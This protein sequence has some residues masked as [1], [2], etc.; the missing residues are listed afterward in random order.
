M[1]AKTYQITIPETAG[2]LSKSLPQSPEIALA[3][4][5]ELKQQADQLEKPLLVSMTVG[6]I[7][8]D[9]DEMLATHD[10]L[11]GLFKYVKEKDLDYIFKFPTSP[12]MVKINVICNVSKIDI[13]VTS[14]CKQ[15]F[16]V[17]SSTLNIDEIQFVFRVKDLSGNYKEKAVLTLD[18]DK[19]KKHFNIDLTQYVRQIPHLVNSSLT[20]IHK[21]G[22]DIIIESIRNAITLRC[23][24]DESYD[25]VLLGCGGRFKIYTTPITYT[26]RGTQHFNNPNNLTNVLSRLFLNALS[27]LRD[28]SDEELDVSSK[29]VMQGI[30]N[31]NQVIYSLVS[32]NINPISG[33]M[34]Y[35]QLFMPTELKKMPFATEMGTII[36]DRLETIN[37]ATEFMK[38]FFEYNIRGFTGLKVTPNEDHADIID[39]MS[40][41]ASRYEM[42]F[43]IANIAKKSI[44]HKDKEEYAN[45]I[46]NR[47]S[48]SEMFRLIEDD[49]V[50]FH[51]SDFRI[52]VVEDGRN[53]RFDLYVE[54]PNN[55]IMDKAIVGYENINLNL[56]FCNE[57]I[58][59]SGGID[60]NI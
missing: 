9:L 22:G 14:T 43:S 32:P 41:R 7:L 16:P 23:K 40:P 6:H 18:N 8:F 52:E 38:E 58:L 51:T 59:G 2:Y 34:S 56:V 48:A 31:D 20:K 19:M 29:F 55:E 42:V 15:H 33:V 24:D 11:R 12:L 39:V 46:A 45:F 36:T 3:M 17:L 28:R 1:E 4:A 60:F 5:N 35:E 37:N 30:S 57:R 53:F 54:F 49:K 27:E 26:K 25:G 13:D 50:I 21:N 47:L 10:F 44:S